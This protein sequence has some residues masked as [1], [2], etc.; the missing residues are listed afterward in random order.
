MRASQYAFNVSPVHP[1]NTLS[2]DAANEF[3]D[4]TLPYVIYPANQRSSETICGEGNLVHSVYCSI[5]L[6]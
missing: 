5:D 2:L 4:I 1:L 3:M 6:I